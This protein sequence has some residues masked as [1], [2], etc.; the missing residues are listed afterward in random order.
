METSNQSQFRRGCGLESNMLDGNMTISADRTRH[1]RA[2]A[3]QV[4]VLDGK[5]RMQTAILPEDSNPAVSTFQFFLLDG[6]RS[7][8]CRQTPAPMWTPQTSYVLNNGTTQFDKTGV[9]AVNSR[10]KRTAVLIPAMSIRRRSNVLQQ[11]TGDRPPSDKTKRVDDLRPNRNVI[12][13]R[14]VVRPW[15]RYCYFPLQNIVL[16]AACLG[17]IVT[18]IEHEMAKR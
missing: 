9:I 4:E 15:R 3:V 2:Q 13:R 8:R 17:D 16:D 11:V 12:R 10:L 14:E 7:T 18:F 6:V 5:G 1:W